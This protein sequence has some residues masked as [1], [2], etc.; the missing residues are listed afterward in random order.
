MEG[1]PFTGLS[2]VAAGTEVARNHKWWTATPF[3]LNNEAFPNTQL[4]ALTTPLLLLLCRYEA[5]GGVYFYWTIL[6][7]SWHKKR[8]ESPVV[9]RWTLL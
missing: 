1:W 6:G 3:C 2:W 9:D 4:T 7:S 8:P 5:Y